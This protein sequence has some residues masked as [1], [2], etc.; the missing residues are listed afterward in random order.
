MEK[1]LRQIIRESSSKTA[2]GRVV[3]YG[4]EEHLEDLQQTLDILLK[5]RDNQKKTSKSRYI[6]ARAAEEAR[7]Q[8][9]RAKK[10][11]VK[12]GLIKE[13]ILRDYVRLVLEGGLKAPE[14]TGSTVLDPQTVQVAIDT[15]KRVMDLWNQDLAQ[16]GLRPVEA[17]GPVG[18][19]AYYQ[20]DLASGS[21]KTYG[22]VDYLVA[23]PV[24]VSDDATPEEER[25]AENLA[26]KEYTAHLVDFLQSSAEA[27]RLV[28][29]PAT[30][31][32]TPTLLIVRLPDGQYVQ[33]DTIITYPHYVEK[34]GE[35]GWMPS[36][37][38]PERGIKGYT[39]GNLYGVLADRYNLSISDRGVL[40]RKRDGE[41]VP[42][43]TR[44]GT[45]LHRVSRNM[46][47]LFAD[48]ARFIAPEAEL[49][50]LLVQ[51]PGMN[52]DSIT[53]ASAARGIVGLVKTLATAGKVG[54]V[55]S[56]L[57]AILKMYEDKLQESI[58]KKL[59]RGLEQEKYD[60]LAELN[61]R[62][63]DIVASE[64]SA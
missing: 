27:K 55:G 54:S 57:S 41:T 30:I 42:F 53:I 61:R 43:R 28:H 48:I 25:K 17:V 63:V 3:E 58:D 32:S 8:L 24:V 37:W 5:L 22:D 29:V 7:K 31:K 23:F 33:V 49:D 6:F 26:G 10:H 44:K 14:L 60:K 62:V 45:Q 64:F 12:A 9:S 34:K 50:E 2:D 40:A 56:E 19:V 11:G 18:S 39:I 16:K 59:D 36:R 13:K 1:Y 47:N 35:G 4:S 38:T 15:Y 20:K 51:Q 52:P 21:D 46:S